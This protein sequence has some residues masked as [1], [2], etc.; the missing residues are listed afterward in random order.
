[1]A[2][3]PLPRFLDTLET[4]IAHA[5]EL[6]RITRQTDTNLTSLHTAHTAAD[7][8][9]LR[10]IPAVGHGVAGVIHGTQPE[11]SACR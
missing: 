3:F 8:I 9:T 11:A 5:R 10:G 1:M 6:E 2:T 4:R 7:A